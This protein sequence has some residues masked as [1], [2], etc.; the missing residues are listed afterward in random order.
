MADSPNNSE[1]IVA[2]PTL[3]EPSAEIIIVQSF[4]RKPELRKTTLDMVVQAMRQPDL[5]HFTAA[6]ITLVH[7][8]HHADITMNLVADTHRNSTHTSR[9]DPRP[10]STVIV[11]TDEQRANGERQTLHV[12]H[13]R[14]QIYTD[15]KLFPEIHEASWTLE[16]ARNIQAALLAE[17]D[18]A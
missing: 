18:S 11:T 12:Y 13:D 17:V 1:P 14:E 5:A 10:H 3:S 15:H 16:H 9:S 8:A 2:Q 6:V 7:T 4:R